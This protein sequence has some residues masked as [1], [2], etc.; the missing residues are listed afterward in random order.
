MPKEKTCK[1][2][3]G[4]AQPDAADLDRRNRKTG[5]RNNAEHQN[6]VRYSVRLFKCLEP[7]HCIALPR[8]SL[9]PH[10]VKIVIESDRDHKKVA[11][12]AALPGLAHR[13]E[14]IKVRPDETRASAAPQMSLSPRLS[15]AQHVYTGAGHIAHDATGSFK[16]FLL[17]ESLKA[18]RVRH[19]LSLMGLALMGVILTFWLPSFPESVFRFFSR[20]LDLQSWPQIIIAK[21]LAGLLFLLS[22]SA[23]QTCSRFL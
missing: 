16:T 5:N 21:F 18:F 19:V 1:K 13:P 17:S 6:R 8:R 4:A 22:G 12:T 23:W 9:S 14:S 7:A 15:T 10:S 11:L 20:V 3:S 2:H